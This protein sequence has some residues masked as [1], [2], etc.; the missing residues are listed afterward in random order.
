M[1]GILQL[2]LHLDVT[3]GSAIAAYGA[4]IYAALFLVVFCE[5]GL[6]VTPF[7]PGDSLLFAAGAFAA[8]GQLD[9]WIVAGLMFAA[10]VLGDAVNYRI[11]RRF[12]A[13]ILAKGSFL[14]LPIR[15]AHIARTQQYY[16]RYGVK[17][18]VFARFIP[19]V[20][21]VAP[22]VAGVGEMGAA[23][24]TKYNVIG[25]ALWT[26]L[27]VLGGYFFGNIPVIK[28]NFEIVILAIVFFSFIPPVFG[29]L[30]E[31]G[32]R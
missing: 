26:A 3:L 16:A 19:I 6:V 2:L 24:F 15:P 32:R 23:T 8:A 14:G 27:F 30:R 22:F 29:Y 21:T 25:G 9:P 10:A 17:T 7:L 5:T 18:I 20:R 31:R 13:L 28:R 4:W 12:G 11:G 1:N